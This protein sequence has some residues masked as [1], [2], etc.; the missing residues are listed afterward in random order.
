MVQSKTAPRFCVLSSRVISEVWI[1]PEANLDVRHLSRSR[2][3]RPASCEGGGYD[4]AS[5]V[6]H[7]DPGAT[8]GSASAVQPRSIRAKTAERL[9]R[10]QQGCVMLS[11]WVGLADRTQCFLPENHFSGA[12]LS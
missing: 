7:I 11:P 9:R 1:G 5:A 6:R 4:L 12:T 10:R 2:R 8:L 3:P